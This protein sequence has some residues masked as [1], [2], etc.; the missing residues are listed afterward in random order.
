GGAVG[1]DITSPVNEAAIDESVERACRGSRIDRFDPAGCHQQPA[2][3]LGLAAQGPRRNSLWHGTPL[4]DRPELRSA[5][6][7]PALPDS[8]GLMA[9]S[10]DG[11]CR[12][13]LPE[14]V[15]GGDRLDVVVQGH[16][17]Q[18]RGLDPGA[19]FLEGPGV[20][21]GVG[22]KRVPA[23]PER[24]FAEPGCL[25]ANIPVRL[26]VEHLSR[27]SVDRRETGV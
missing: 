14:S 5:A 1:A 8:D 6:Y 2:E 12:D 21:V 4:P 9:V 11:V 27:P 15:P 10:R 18:E 25:A 7:Q 24:C 13:H 26:L 3:G 22:S 17:L 23:V 16:D 20:I 19:Y